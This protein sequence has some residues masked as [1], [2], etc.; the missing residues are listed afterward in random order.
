MTI[1]HD[2]TLYTRRNQITRIFGHLKI[3]RAIARR[4]DQLASSILGMV[5]F[6]T[7]RYCVKFVHAA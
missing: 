4:Y 1:E 3:N 2:R 7:A 5:H 6:V